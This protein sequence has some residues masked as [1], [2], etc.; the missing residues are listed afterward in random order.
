MDNK[1]ILAKL[2]EIML[3]IFDDDSIN[4]TEETTASD[5]DEWDSFAQM[6]IIVR[7]EDEFHVRFEVDEM[8]ELAC[9]GDLVNLIFRKIS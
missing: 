6:N 7:C 5:V 3:D 2:T 8:A 9:V 4:I 1:S